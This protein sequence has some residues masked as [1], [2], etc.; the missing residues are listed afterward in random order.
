MPGGTT[1]Q[2]YSGGKLST[3]L[4]LAQ[5][6]VRAEHGM[7]TIW[8]DYSCMRKLQRRNVK[9]KSSVSSLQHAP[10]TDPSINVQ[11]PAF[12]ALADMEICI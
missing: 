5:T 3:A 9:M 2:R 12:P 8:T 10:T 4:I 11:I 7:V 6:D 1:A